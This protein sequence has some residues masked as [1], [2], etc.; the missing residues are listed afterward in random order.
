VIA[1]AESGTSGERHAHFAEP[2]EIARA[3]L[4]LTSDD[5]SW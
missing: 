3:A 1:G 2:D 4:Y 5:S